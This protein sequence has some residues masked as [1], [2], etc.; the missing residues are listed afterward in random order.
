[1]PKRVLLLRT[2]DD[3][4]L[5]GFILTQVRT[6]KILRDAQYREPNARANESTQELKKVLF[7]SAVLAG[8]RDE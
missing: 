2:V 5:P 3:R 1:M 4:N 8:V 7:R 6:V